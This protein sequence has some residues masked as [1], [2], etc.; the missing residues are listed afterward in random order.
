MK[1]ST[2]PPGLYSKQI[3]QSCRAISE[4]AWKAR[5]G[6]VDDP[7]A[8]ERPTGSLR[9]GAPRGLPRARATTRCPRLNSTLRAAAPPS[10]EARGPVH[11]LDGPALR[12]VWHRRAVSGRAVHRLRRRARGAGVPRPARRARGAPHP[13]GREAWQAHPGFAARHQRP[14]PGGAPREPARQRVVHRRLHPHDRRRRG[15]R[16]RGARRLAG[17]PFAA[18][19]RPAV[20]QP[21]GARAR[22]AGGPLPK[23]RNGEG[24]Q[25]VVRRPIRRECR[26]RPAAGRVCCAGAGRG[27][28]AGGAAGSVLGPQRGGRRGPPGVPDAP[29]APRARRRQP[30]LGRLGRRCG[31]APRPDRAGGAAA[32]RAD[33]RRRGRAA[34]AARGAAAAAGALDAPNQRGPRAVGRAPPAA[35][36]ARRQ[37]GGADG[38]DEPLAAARP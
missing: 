16:R 37:R 38:A 19:R 26:R 27:D 12:A 24:R 31:G 21:A 34:A 6:R 5:G 22:R 11:R 23:P 10:Q 17:R 20:Q 32:A 29:H 33:R 3:A 35:A 36:A 2:V 30:G 8:G 14:L 18:V 1:A 4:A 7:F 9:S 13:S 25:G 15:R 28:A